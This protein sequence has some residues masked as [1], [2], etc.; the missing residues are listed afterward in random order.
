MEEDGMRG[1]SVRSGFQRKGSMN[2]QWFVQNLS[3]LYLSSLISYWNNPFRISHRTFQYLLIS[4]NYLYN[5]LSAV[6]SNANDDG[7]KDIVDHSYFFGSGLLRLWLSRFRCA[8]CGFRW[9]GFWC[10][11]FGGSQLGIDVEKDDESD[12]DETHDEYSLGLDLEPCAFFRK[13]LEASALLRW[14]SIIIINTCN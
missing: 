6:A 5:L 2:L 4:T 7:Y 13:V 12:V 8:G 11:S 9:C 1:K 10:D 3:N 14:H